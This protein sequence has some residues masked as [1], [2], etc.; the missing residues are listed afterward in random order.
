[1]IVRARH[2]FVVLRDGLGP[3][4][5]LAALG[6]SG[7]LYVRFGSGNFARLAS[8]DM[9]WHVDFESFWRSTVALRHGTDLYRT[10]MSTI[11]LDPPLLAVLML[12]LAWLPALPAYHLFALLNLVLIVGSVV[13]V[14]ERVRL[15]PGWAMVAVAALLASSPLHGTLALGQVYGLLTAAITVAWLAERRGRAVPAGVAVGL[16]IALKPSLLPLLAWP[17]L[18]RSVPRRRW[19]AA[20]VAAAS[21]ATGIGALAA[22]WGATAEWV[23]VLHAVRPD[24]FLDN[25]SLACLAVRF[26]LPTW[27]G[28]AVA[29]VLMVVTLYRARRRRALAAWSITSAALLLAPI[30]WNNYLVLLAPAVPLLLAMGRIRATLPLLALPLIGIEWSWL[31]DQ[32]TLGRIGASLYCGMLLTFWAVLTFGPADPEP[33]VTPGAGRAGE[34]RPATVGECRRSPVFALDRR[35]PER[36]PL[37]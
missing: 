11:N 5:A 28:Y 13:V 23:G 19:L 31:L 21:A 18:T 26:G 29:S 16:A 7:W 37:L 36:S 34:Q 15:R 9:Y 17:L 27:P 1:M 10:G 4:L 22:G 20:A 33:G 2:L 35:S 6:L 25:D 24:G 8:T 12:P 32:D 30:A 14:A 3:A